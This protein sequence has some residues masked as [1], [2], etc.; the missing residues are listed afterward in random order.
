[1]CEMSHKM[2]LLRIVVFVLFVGVECINA[3]VLF[4]LNLRMSWN[5]SF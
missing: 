5:A 1:M 3:H 4:A 2:Q